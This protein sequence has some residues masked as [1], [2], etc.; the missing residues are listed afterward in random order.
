[1]KHAFTGMVLLA[2]A[3]CI[4]HSPSQPIGYSVTKKLPKVWIEI[5]NESQIALDVQPNRRRSGV[6]SALYGHWGINRKF[7][8]RDHAQIAQAKVGVTSD[9]VKIGLELDIEQSDELI[10]L[11]H[12]YLGEQVIGFVELDRDL[13]HD[14]IV[15]KRCSITFFNDR[16]EFSVGGV[17]RHVV[18]I[19]NPKRV[20]NTEGYIS[21]ND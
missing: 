20:L 11:V 8:P 12:S 19:V 5:A 3:G 2:C 7:D 18:W 16:I 15:G 9:Q 4:S 17:K 1:V 6:I 10:F 13:T 21:P 14:V